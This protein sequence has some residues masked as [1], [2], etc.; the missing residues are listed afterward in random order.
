MSYT[1][2]AFLLYFKFTLT[3]INTT[4]M[5]KILLAFSILAIFAAIPACTEDDDLISPDFQ[6]QPAST[7]QDDNNGAGPKG[8]GG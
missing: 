3:H 2:R 4:I 1:F 5:K 7:D 8:G 6:E